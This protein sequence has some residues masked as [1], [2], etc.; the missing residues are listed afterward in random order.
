MDNEEGS[1]FAAWSA[2]HCRSAAGLTR[3]Y[4]P[5]LRDG[6]AAVFMSSRARDTLTPSCVATACAFKR[7]SAP[8]SVVT[9]AGA[10]VASAIARATIAAL[11]ARI[12]ARRTSG[13]RERAVVPSAIT[14]ATTA[15][16][17]R[18]V[19]RGAPLRCS[20]AKRPSIALNPRHSASERQPA[21]RQ[22]RRYARCRPRTAHGKN[23]HWP[24]RRR[25]SPTAA[26][27]PSGVGGSRRPARA[28]IPA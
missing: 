12:A 27:P 23:F 15:P 4:R 20:L 9:C 1:G 14:S 25:P 6:R 11:A 28:D 5:T 16:S 10:D 18:S 17:S 13:A 24:R 2:T 22:T 3:R 21:V 8:A 7:G 26:A 19:T